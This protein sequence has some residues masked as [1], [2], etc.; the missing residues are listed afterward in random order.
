MRGQLK[1]GRQG[2]QRVCVWGGRGD[3]TIHHHWH[4][5]R[6]QDHDTPA[7]H[8]VPIVR[9]SS[10]STT[11]RRSGCSTEAT[12]SGQPLALPLARRRSPPPAPLPSPL[13]FSGCPPCAAWCACR[14]YACDE[15]PHQCASPPA[16]I[17]CFAGARQARPTCKLQASALPAALSP[18]RPC[19]AHGTGST[20]PAAMPVG[21]LP[22]PPHRRGRTRRV[23]PPPLVCPHTYNTHKQLPR[24]PTH[25]QRGTGER[26]RLHVVN[27]RE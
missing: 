9:W 2:E 7:A 5:A 21:L 25:H 14:G 27:S 6:R 20:V 8:G 18:F 16:L 23:P 24:A 4:C 13:L 1:T 10:S 22:Q 17:F 12:V 3:S 19:K 15:G 11:C 26:D